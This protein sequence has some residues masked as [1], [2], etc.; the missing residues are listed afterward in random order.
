M[1]DS[2]FRSGSQNN[3]CRH[4]L[5]ALVS[6]F[7][8]DS[9]TPGLI[10]AYRFASDGRA[11]KLPDS[12]VIRLGETDQGFLWVHLNLLGHAQTADWI[13]SQAI[14]PPQV[15]TMLVA[16]G[17]HQ[18]IDFNEEFLWGIFADVMREHNG[19]EHSIGHLRFALGPNF[20]LSA[21]RHSLTS[22]EAARLEVEAGR[23]IT[24]PIALLETIIDH[25]LAVIN[26]RVQVLLSDIDSI[27]DNVLDDEVR[28]ERQRLGPL[29]RRAVRIHRQ[30]Y[31]LMAIFRR[32]EHG[33]A[34]IHLPND[35]EA[36]A[37]RLI[38][39]IDSLIHETHSIQERARL[40]QDEVS[41]KLTS[42]TNSHL[43]VLT[44]L[45]TLLLPPTLV[46]G[47]FGMNTKG[48]PF[49]DNE[50]AFLFAMAICLIC[51]GSV[52]LVMRRR[53]MI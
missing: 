12:E 10:W 38:Q 50:D 36:T 15:K 18:Q 1:I 4:I 35:L 52:Y 34:Q 47:I 7:F 24:G 45:T 9:A 25:A 8:A 29:R 30:L 42:R 28:D 39:R 32:L 5:P 33:R 22:A 6:P 16:S 20:L 41:S 11:E 48:L 44:I 46:T 31:G 13:M 23:A 17:E 49:T 27:E 3:S 14:L 21:R 51:S 53:G 40:L 26:D 37:T 43:Y 19:S 2:P